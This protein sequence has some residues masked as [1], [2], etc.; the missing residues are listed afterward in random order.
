MKETEQAYKLKIIINKVEWLYFVMVVWCIILWVY[1]YIDEFSFSLLFLA[2]ICNSILCIIV[3]CNERERERERER[4]WVRSP[5]N[6]KIRNSIFFILSLRW[7]TSFE[8][9]F[10]KKKKINFVEKFSK[11]VSKS[12][13]SIE[14]N[15]LLVKLVLFLLSSITLKNLGFLTTRI[16]LNFLKN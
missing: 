6:F 10:M 4:E 9:N 16:S 13:S 3:T 1:K 7:L 8:T 15:F 2:N 5:E 11:I 12:F 14:I